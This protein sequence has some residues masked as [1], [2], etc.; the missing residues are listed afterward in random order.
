MTVWAVVHGIPVDASADLIATLGVSAC[1]D[2][3]AAINHVVVGYPRIIENEPC[4]YFD[5][6]N[7]AGW[8]K[9]S[10]L[11]S[12]F[13]PDGRTVV[14]EAST[15]LSDEAIPLTGVPVGDGLEF[16][17]PPLQ[18]DNGGAVRCL[19]TFPDRVVA[20]AYRD[21]GTPIQTVAAVP[22]EDGELQV[23]VN[24][25]TALIRLEPA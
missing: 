10:D 19:H 18:A 5:N 9:V 8:V 4:K 22:F 20:L 17:V 11:G 16:T 1:N 13:E 14:W 21:D 2:E 25:G 6:G 7:D 23:Q 24:A 12:Q 3:A 15:R